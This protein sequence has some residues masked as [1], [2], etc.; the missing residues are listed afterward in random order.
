MDKYKPFTFFCQAKSPDWNDYNL[1]FMLS[2]DT[3]Y[4]A[5]FRR[6][7]LIGVAKVFLLVLLDRLRRLM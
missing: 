1:A 7:R 3:A 6:L 2:T 4:E 5:V